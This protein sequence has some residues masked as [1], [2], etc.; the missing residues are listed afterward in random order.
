MMRMSAAA[1]ARL[2]EPWEEFIG[3]VYDDKR[4][5]EHT[6]GRWQYPE[7]DGGAVKG[8]LTI[9]FGHTDAAGEPFIK[10][11]MRITRAQADEILSKDMADCEARVNRQ[12]KVKPT[13]HQFDAIADT[14]FNCPVAATAAIKLINSG[15]PEQVPAKLLQYTYS[16][17]EHMEGLTH[18]RQAE[19]AWFNHP[20]DAPAPAPVAEPHPDIV[21]CPKAERN[22]PPKSMV[23]SKTG[24]AAITGGGI[25]A[26]LALQ[27]ANDVL[28]QVTAVQG[29]LTSIVPAE[30][31]MAIAA[32]PKFLACAAIVGFCIFMWGDR[33]YKLQVHHV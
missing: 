7:W 28:D 12:F 3:Y 25:G 15:H 18:R 32:D 10:Q 24:T 22:P 11:G 1:R 9:G 23:E 26:S 16:K 21:F 33:F 14:E 13:Q 31:L 6:N 20:D 29:K 5:K 27:R 8:T 4:P 2:T 19:N 30:H 17:G